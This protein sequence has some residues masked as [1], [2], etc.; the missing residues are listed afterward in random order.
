MAPPE[1][2][3][4]DA[5]T[6]L[7][8]M[9]PAVEQLA[10]CLRDESKALRVRDAAALEAAVAGK[11]MALER[12]EEATA[13]LRRIA[14]D[15]RERAAAWF[16]AHGAGPR[17]AAIGVR[18]AE[19]ERHNAVNGALIEMGRTLNTRLLDLL[20]GAGGERAP[21]LYGPSGRVESDAGSVS[22]GRS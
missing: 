8:A 1:A 11:R 22:I 13:T 12:L 7:A 16:D 15:D 3:P 9:E 4:Q 6:L 5:A 2:A 19:L 17:W 14:G 21:A 20:R 10:A 18:L